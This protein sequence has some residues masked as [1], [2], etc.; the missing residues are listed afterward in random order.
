MS[1]RLRISADQ[2]GGDSEFHPSWPKG[3]DL[4]PLT[5]K[6]LRSLKLIL[7]NTPRKNPRLPHPAR[8]LLSAQIQRHRRRCTSTLSRPGGLLSQMRYEAQTQA[9]L[10]II[11]LV[12]AAC[13]TPEALPPRPIDA[14]SAECPM[15]EYPIEAR[16]TEAMGVTRV[17]MTVSSLGTVTETT[18]LRKSGQSRFHDLLDQAAVKAVQQCRFPA[19]SGYGPAKAVREFNWQ[20][21]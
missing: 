7:N 4:S 3:L 10:A 13:A 19:A 1:Q 14:S 5:D 17:L 20:L 16:R 11:V 8:S 15:P 21:H 6:D 18:I 2:A 9:L 12:M